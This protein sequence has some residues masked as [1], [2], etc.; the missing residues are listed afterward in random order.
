MEEEKM[1]VVSTEKSRSSHR[2]VSLLSQVKYEHLVAGI[3]GG[4]TSTLVLHPLDIIKT[5]FA[6]NDGR[7]QNIPKYN[8]TTN[9]FITIYKQE[10]FTGLYRGV[11]PNVLGAGASWGLYFLFYNT[12]KMKLQNGNIDKPLSATQHLICASEGGFVTLLITNPLWVMKTRMCLQYDGARQ[13]YDGA[14]DCCMKIYR[15]HG[16]RGF[17]KGLIP[18]IFGVSHGAVHFVVY[19]ELKRYYSTYKSQPISTKLGTLEYLAFA[20][21]SKLVAAT[22]TFPYQVIRTRLQNQNYSYNGLLD[23]LTQTWQYEG[24]RGFY[25]GLG[26]NLVRVI[27]ATMITFVTYENISH[28]LLTYKL[29]ASANT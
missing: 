17:Y 26:P 10:G 12:L 4:V 3:S 20:A 22:V 7:R 2:P 25:K 21:T 11:T 23:C 29:N 27:P 1:S 9:A 6:V 15:D 14:I 28:L 24:W 5:R 16:A 18:G 13:K 8:G 19:E